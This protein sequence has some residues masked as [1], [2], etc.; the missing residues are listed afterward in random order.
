MSRKPGRGGQG[1][2]GKQRP[3]PPKKPSSGKSKP[4][5]PSKPGAPSGPH[6]G[7]GPHHHHGTRQTHHKH[8]QTGGPGT[9]K[10]R[11]LSPGACSCAA[12]ALAASL[13][14][15]GFE[16]TEHDVLDLYYLTA[17]GPD[18]GASIEETLAA[19]AETG[20][21]GIRLASYEE[22]MPSEPVEYGHRVSRA[23]LILGVNVPGPHTVYDDGACWWSWG[24]R[25]PA[26]ADAEERWKV[27]WGIML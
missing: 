8:H 1:G 14:L 10:K 9:G 11:G 13:R 2:G 24:A 23:G 16:V 27:A 5:A 22:V 19:A 6:H 3:T 7:H 26:F 18:D 20:L 12:E 17:N 21:A 25:W 15:A 4:K